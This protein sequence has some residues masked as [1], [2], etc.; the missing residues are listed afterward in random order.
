MNTLITLISLTLAY[1]TPLIFA[2]LGGTFSEKSGVTNVGLE[3]IMIAGAF[4]SVWATYTT[5]SLI[6]GV[7]AAIAAG[8]LIALLHAFLCVTLR[9]D[10]VVSGVAINVL[11]TSLASF[12]VI[13]IWGMPGQS[14]TVKSFGDVN[15]PLLSKIPYIKDILSNWSI[16]VY[17]AVILVFVSHYV[18]F[19]TPFGLRMRAVGENP[20][21]ADTLGI[22]VYRT[23]Y[24]GVLLSGVLAGLGGA[25]LSIGSLGIFR[26]G[27]TSGKGF[28][29]LG[30]MIFGKWTPIGS[31]LACLLFGCAD[32]LQMIFQSSKVPTEFFASIPY[33]V[34]IVALTGFVGK[35]RAPEAD[36]I[37]YEKGQR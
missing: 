20:S 10:Q 25:S 21:A 34:T 19:K 17:I 24:I 3:G 28:I 36:G 18:L 31:L 23:R 32:S 14:A 27:M 22:N 35:S 4:A 26:E 15:I 6:L 12:L 2:A 30:A 7:I 37:P 11:M 5:H 13:Q 33:I 16:F 9:A 29:A 1:S 8:M